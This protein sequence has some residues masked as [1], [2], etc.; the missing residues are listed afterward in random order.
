MFSLIQKKYFYSSIF[1]IL[2]LLTHIN[3]LQGQGK[4]YGT[5]LIRNYSSDHYNAAPENHAV[6]QLDQGFTYFANYGHII[7]Y[8]GNQWRK[9][10]IKPGRQ[11]LSIGAD[12]LGTIYVSAGNDFGYLYPD[13]NGRL[14]YYSLSERA[15]SVDVH[16][17]GTGKV[18]VTKEGI[19]FHTL[20]YLFH[21]PNYFKK[22]DLKE[23]KT[24][25]NPVI[26]KSNNTFSNSFKAGEYIFVEDEQEGLHILK[27]DTL[28][29]I[30]FKN[31][32]QSK[33]VAVLPMDSLRVLICT[34]DQMY[35]YKI[36]WGFISFDAETEAFLKQIT[37]LHAAEIP[38]A[39]VFATQNKGTIILDKA[40]KGRK[41]RIIEQLTRQSGLPTEQVTDIYNNENVNK[42]LIWLT[43][44]YGIS[45]VFLNTPVRKV[46]EAQNVKDVIHDIL[47]VNDQ[48]FFRTFG[49]I[50]SLKD[51]LGSY[52]FSSFKN[53]IS[54]TDWIEFPIEFELEKNKKRRWSRYRVKP[55]TVTKNTLLI[56]S[57]DG[58]FYI[59]GKNAK[60]V[61]LNNRIYIHKYKEK[62]RYAL[63]NPYRRNIRELKKINALYRS[64]IYP[65][66]VYAGTK[67]GLI[68]LS[69][70]N[71]KW[72][73]E[74]KIE[75]IKGEISDVIEDPSGNVWASAKN[76]G[77]YQ[78]SIPDTVI[79]IKKRSEYGTW[80]DSIAFELFPMHLSQVKYYSTDNKLPP[81]LENGFASTPFDPLLF[82]TS[83]GPFIFENDQNNFIKHNKYP[84]ETG[85][86]LLDIAM[87]KDSAIWARKRDDFN[88]EVLHFV[89]M[90]NNSWGIDSSLAI[91]FPN[92]TVTD[93]FP[94]Q[95]GKVWVSGTEGLYIYD[96]TVKRDTTKSFQAFIRKVSIAND[97]VIFWGTDYRA[98]LDARALT[99]SFQ[100]P[101]RLYP[102]LNYTENNISFDFAAPYFDNEQA[103]RYSFRLKGADENWS[104][105]SDN[106]H[107][108]YTN[109]KEGAYVFEVRA[110]NIYGEQSGLAS[111]A[112]KVLPPWYRTWWAYVLYTISIIGFFWIALKLYTRKLKRD[113]IKLERIIEKRTA[114]IV[115]QKDEIEVKNKEIQASIT[116]ASRIQEAMLPGEDNFHKHF[117]EHFV[118]FKPRDQVSG[119]FYWFGEKNG[120][121][122][123]A[124]VDCTGHGV[125]GAFMSM[126][127]DALLNQIIFENNITDPDKILFFLHRSIRKM[128]KQHQTDNRDGMDLSMCLIDT[129]E[130]NI[131]FAG[132]KNPLLFIYNGEMKQ[133]K[134]DPV[135]I[136]GVQHEEKRVFKSHSLSF[137]NPV[138]LYL[139]SDGYQDQFGG[140]NGMKFLSGRFKKLLH[141]I[142]DKPMSEQKAILEGK[143]YEWMNDKYYQI[144]DIL[145]LGVRLK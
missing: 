17:D 63:Y 34:T 28:L 88:T 101:K 138:C 119:D 90:G 113:K 108:E 100:Q 139:F 12:S 123:L 56:A 74:G 120:K 77:V 125:P 135:P 29:P 104:E 69:Y 111:F 75:G 55:K 72:I 26:I 110:K 32:L 85:D 40:I 60:E 102:V 81:M 95:E 145:V 30:K 97:S 73:F 65:F 37:I 10:P 68:I 13:L 143:L 33:V 24:I 105:W 142:H 46:V 61:A 21:Y 116:Y 98:S 128:L 2:L 136:G 39:F 103:I 36:G 94:D 19:Y 14:T 124:A 66:R 48:F 118:L 57:L 144:D 92:M 52:Q 51:T 35:I 20:H 127:G 5:P 31:F 9:I 96:P 91:S 38:N 78:V 106:K 112:F 4:K 107:K 87:D 53:I 3:T 71:R 140:K 41:R 22:V 70:Q 117:K 122:I 121:I 67:D 54:N 59:D 93:V 79:T 80:R 130:R 115:K 86:R 43:S 132:A 1:I 82:L 18:H 64:S 99:L 126:I 89:K 16:Q 137:E 49:E 11:V 76:K 25:E 27:N 8:D 141:E 58:L 44:I 7:E 114:E 84:L 134:G 133:I 109:L 42:D 131:T 83:Q 50:Y 62:V 47:I 15:D 129:K 45:K 6:V 23:L